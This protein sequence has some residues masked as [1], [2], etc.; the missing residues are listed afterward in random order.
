MSDA[1]IYLS[2]EFVHKLRDAI[3]D[4]DKAMNKCCLSCREPESFHVFNMWLAL[5]VDLLAGIKVEE[6]DEQNPIR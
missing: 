5:K 4:M 2:H 3:C 1:K 6:K